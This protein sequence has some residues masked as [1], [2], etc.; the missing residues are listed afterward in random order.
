M[1]LQH[2]VTNQV[3]KYRQ[4]EAITKI[5]TSL[6]LLEKR[7]GVYKIWIMTV[8]EV[9]KHRTLLILDD[10]REMVFHLGN[11]DSPD[12]ISGHRLRP[13]PDGLA[14]ARGNR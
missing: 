5:C 1:T 7:V 6:Y 2:S 8:L 12:P 14:T 4:R 9:L 13:W 10:N 3:E 11:G